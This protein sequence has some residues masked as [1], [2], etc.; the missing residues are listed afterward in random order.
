V[1]E[2]GA[3][4]GM[5]GL[6]GPPNPSV[7]AEPGE[8]DITVSLSPTARAQARTSRPRRSSSMRKGLDS[9]ATESAAR[10]RRSSSMRNVMDSFSRVLD[11]EMRETRE[12]QKEQR[13]ERLRRKSLTMGS[14]RGDRDAN[15]QRREGRG[16]DGAPWLS[17]AALPI[18]EWLNFGG[19]GENADPEMA[20]ETS[21]GVVYI[22]SSQR[23]SC[24]FPPKSNPVV[25]SSG[26]ASHSRAP[27]VRDL[28][29]SRI[30]HAEESPN[31][32]EAKSFYFD[33]THIGDADGKTPN[34]YTNNSNGSP[35][36]RL[37]RSEGNTSGKQHEKEKIRTQ[38][39]AQLVMARDKADM[40]D[41]PADLDNPDVVK[42][43][44]WQ[45]PQD[46]SCVDGLHQQRSAD[47]ALRLY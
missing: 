17:S 42:E 46:I 31:L 13:D 24:P 9:F 8:S 45:Q 22:K 25:G 26:Q 23:Q 7:P 27:H 41:E 33:G 3:F 34:C 19:G 12:R 38:V 2:W 43:E 21:P 1:G 6:E 40:L 15:G 39:Q 11:D 37:G 14:Q 10:P 16:D 32:N 4:V 35:A 44:I 36:R 18:Q 30:Q 28:R 47:S 5:S 20:R 29:G